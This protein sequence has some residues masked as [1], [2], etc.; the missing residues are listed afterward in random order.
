VDN[1]Q[2]IQVLSVMRKPNMF[3]TFSTHTV[4]ELILAN[5]RW[6]IVE[7]THKLVE[8]KVEDIDMSGG[9]AV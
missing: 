8:N 2:E 3:A 9:K 1:G 5:K 6:I 4:Y 7:I